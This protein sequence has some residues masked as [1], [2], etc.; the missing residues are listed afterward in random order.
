MGSRFFLNALDER[1]TSLVVPKAG[2]WTRDAACDDFL[3]RYAASIKVQGQI[4][5][6]KVAHSVPS[7]FARPIQFFQALADTKHPLHSAVVSEWRGLLGMF[8]LQK[9]VGLTLVVK[10][11]EV[12]PVPLESRKQGPRAA[13]ELAAGGTADHNITTML[14]NQLPHRVED[15]QHWWLL[16]CNDA[17]IGA[18]SPWTIAYPAAWYRCPREIPWQNQ[19]HLLKDP[20]ACYDPDNA[21]KASPELTILLR[22]IELV[23]EGGVWGMS[24]LLEAKAGVILRELQTWKKALEKYRVNSVSVLNLDARSLVDKDPYRH[25]MRAPLETGL[26][27]FASDQIL[28]TREGVEETLVFKRH[29][30]EST[31]RVWG[32][33][34]V[35]QVDLEK[36]KGPSGSPG[37][38]SRTGAAVPRPYLIAEEAF[39]PPKLVELDLSPNALSRG[40]DKFA[41]PLTPT[42]FKYLD[43]KTLYE[44]KDVLTVAPTGESVVVRLQLPLTNGGTLNVEKTY[45]KS[46]DVVKVVGP[47]PALA[48]WPDFLVKDWQ[49][50]FAV[51]AAPDLTNLVVAPLLGDG[52]EVRATSPDQQLLR[53]WPLQE[54]SIGFALYQVYTE[55]GSNMAGLHPVGVVLR[56]SLRTPVDSNPHVKWKAAVDF[57]TSSTHVLVDRAGGGASDLR[58]HGRTLMLTMAEPTMQEAAVS[59]LYPATP[60]DAPFPTLLASSLKK[61][62]ILAAQP[63]ASAYSPRFLFYPQSNEE[64]L[65]DVKWGKGGGASDL[66]LKEYLRSI[67][68]LVACE[69]R[70]AGVGELRFE[71]AFPLAL[72]NGTQQAMADFWTNVTTELTKPGGLTVRSG[73]GIS[74]S[75]AV[76]RCL[77]TAK[78]EVLPLLADGLSIA[79]DVGGGSTDIGFWSG[80]KLLDEVSLKLAGNDLLPP[81]WNLP[82]CVEHIYSVCTGGRW[83][84]AFGSRFDNRPEIF[85]NSVL[86]QTP[87]AGKDPRAHLFVIDLFKQSYGEPPW[88]QV[89]SLIYLF[90]SGLA[91]YVGLH[92]RK[93]TTSMPAVNI[94][95]GGRGSSFLAWIGNPRTIE[96]VLLASFQEGFAR[97]MPGNK[98]GKAVVRSPAISFA[99]SLAPKQEVAKGLLSEPVWAA[100]VG[101]RGPRRSTIPGETNWLDSK[102]NPVAWDAYLEATDVCGLTPP[103]NHESSYIAHFMSV[104]TKER[105]EDLNLDPRLTSLWDGSPNFSA[106]VQNY[107][108]AGASDPSQMVLQPIFACELKAVMG[109]YVESVFRE[110]KSTAASGA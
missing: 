10:P 30:L 61:A 96:Q 102:N 43:L 8:A 13:V 3:Q 44:Q 9:A 52:L 24:G 83:D 38:I 53:I 7:V 77:A 82:K 66:P 6:A 88:M 46:T 103:V 20:I 41:L 21:E 107:L 105:I 106:K 31:R 110:E 97:D 14:R 35:D 63:T 90:F 101:R 84:E 27:G 80:A 33:V 81:F 94:Y 76:C 100:T 69:A 26:P 5:D 2:A 67:V 108:R 15:W 60:I 23:L 40:T 16:Y 45:S 75:D 12:P 25:F 28:K 34:F 51:C 71:W 78:P 58:M 4:K 48:L 17:L 36:L 74:E 56:A 65:R 37:W 47:S 99:A 64:Y 50:N 54:G 42:F 70:D 73:P 68:R 93:T 86:A 87:G 49:E 95:F 32:A 29:G 98:G 104:I 39:F 22:W 85:I 89:R 72:P 92:A 1:D 57:G 79:V 55:R 109:Q 18:T 59:G 62:S 19:K 91:F 11:Y